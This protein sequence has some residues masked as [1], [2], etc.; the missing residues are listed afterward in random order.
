MNGS[1][2]EVSLNDRFLIETIREWYRVQIVSLH[3]L[4]SDTGKAIYQ[5]ELTNRACWILRVG[6]AQGRANFGELAQLLLFFEQHNYPAE[7]VVLTVEQTPVVTVSPWHLLMTTCLVGIPLPYTSE[8][9][10][11]LGAM[12]GRLHTLK[13]ALTFVSAPAKMLPSGELAFALRQ[14]E[15]IAPR[16]PRRYVTQYEWLQQA[17]VS[18][19]R[20]AHLPMT[21]I[22]TDCHPANAL[23][24]APGHITLLDWEEAGI[25]PAVQDV[26]FLLLNCDGKA[27]WDVLS[28]E[29]FHPNAALLQA[30]IEGYCC[31]YRLTAEELDYLPTALRFRSLVY[32]ACSF[33][34]AIA[35]QQKA[36]FS[37]W[38]WQRYRAAEEIAD[39]ARECFE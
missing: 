9:F 10:S 25:G 35:Q 8:A 38:W 11:L 27:P 17:I 30:V 24:T 15:A 19:D 13:P 2:V 4:P 26:A 16:L 7:R 37:E 14:L 6:E 29:V 20:G 39:M 18:L 31:H 28:S 5:V 34:A 33:A 23:M 21:L 3:R 36:E 22:H 12:V 1:N 32:G